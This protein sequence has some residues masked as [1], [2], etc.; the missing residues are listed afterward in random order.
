MTFSG[1]LAAVSNCQRSPLSDHIDL[2]GNEGLRWQQFAG[3]ELHLLLNDHPWTH[4]IEPYLAEFQTLTGIQPRPQVVP[5]PDYFQVMERVIRAEPAQADVFFLPMDSTAYRFWNE[6]LLLPLTPFIGDPHLTAPTYN[7]FDFPEGFRL[8][9]MY[10]PESEEKE[11]YGIPATFE[12]YIL[13]YNKRLVNQYAGGQI[14]KSLDDLLVAAADINRQGRG[15]VFGAVMRGVPADTILDTV[16]GIVLD[17][18][19]QRPAPLPYNIWFDGDWSQPRLSDARIVKGLEAY[20][21]LMQAGP[22]NIKAMNWLEATQ[23]FQA[24]KAAFYIDAS[25]FG[26]GF[27]DPSQSTIAGDVGY[28]TLPPVD[29]SSLTGHWLW[30][31]GIPRTAR[32][33]QAA[34]MFIQWATSPSMEAKIGVA[35]GGA[36]RFSSWLTPSVY[37]EAMNVDYA[38]AVQTAM[39]TSRSTAV[40]HPQW[41]R[42]AQAI[43]M[44]LHEIYDGEAAETAVARLEMQIRQIMA[45][46][47]PD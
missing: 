36:P 44:T 28:A 4:G 2:N 8:T 9:A 46:P 1:L 14:P 43:A 24:G 11:L 27:E 12:A 23:L 37:T 33:P 30:G 35:T 25:L 31:L 15:E 6:A 17:C 20:T 3:T 40:L 7:L 32:Q 42:V 26:P 41:H 10:P 47:H 13:F 18:W 16:T 45:G 39:Q 19:G 29:Q 21:R 22:A 38:L 34:W 5:E